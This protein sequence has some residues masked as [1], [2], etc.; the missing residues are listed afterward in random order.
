MNGRSSKNNV[1]IKSRQQVCVF[2]SDRWTCILQWQRK[3]RGKERWVCEMTRSD[4]DGTVYHVRIFLKD[5]SKTLPMLIFAGF[6]SLQN[7]CPFVDEI[8]HSLGKMQMQLKNT[9]WWWSGS[10]FCG[11]LR[12]R[13]NSEIHDAILVSLSKISSTYAVAKMPWFSCNFTLYVSMY[14]CVYVYMYVCMYTLK[15]HSLAD[16]HEN[17]PHHPPCTGNRNYHSGRYLRKSLR[18]GELDGIWTWYDPCLLAKETKFP[19]WAPRCTN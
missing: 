1:E 15:E 16:G 13:S 7:V 4:G 3:E 2:F 18:Y 9:K 14:V 8:S 10:V 5:K 6:T 17:S 12:I 11:W 19:T